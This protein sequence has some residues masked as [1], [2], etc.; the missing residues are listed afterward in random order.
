MGELCSA[1]GFRVLVTCILSQARGYLL[2]KTF[3][4]GGLG[5]SLRAVD[6]EAQYPLH[7]PGKQGD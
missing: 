3:Q 5:E 1:K 6:L 2:V 7:M 4:L